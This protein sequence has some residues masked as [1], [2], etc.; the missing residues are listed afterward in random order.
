VQDVLGTAS[1]IKVTY[2]NIPASAP[3][4]AKMKIFKDPNQFAD[5]TM[6]TAIPVTV[7]LDAT[8]SG[9]GLDFSTL[10]GTVNGTKFFYGSAPP[11]VPRIVPEHLTVRVGG[12]LLT[13]LPGNLASDSAFGH[14]T[15]TYQPSRP[16]LLAGSNTAQLDAVRD[17]AGNVQAAPTVQPFTYP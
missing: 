3:T 12:R 10:R 8:D 14:V 9:S 13:T 6:V 2:K 7:V 11:A 5:V 1:Q 15:I 16:K 17:R 4:S